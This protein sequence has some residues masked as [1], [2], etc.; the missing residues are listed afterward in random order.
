M[1]GRPARVSP[2]SDVG[3]ATSAVPLADAP[4]GRVRPGLPADAPE[5]GLARA[6][7][8]R[9]ADLRVHLWSR[10]RQQTHLV[11][12]ARPGGNGRE[13]WP[14]PDRPDWSYAAA[15]PWPTLPAE[16]CEQA[17]AG[18]RDGATG[19]PRRDPWPALPDD[20]ELWAPAVTARDADRL[21]RLDRE[22]AGD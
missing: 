17:G 11:A 1:V 14:A 6:A 7:T 12:P 9:A 15:G 10:G 5:L 20:G 4:P 21:A 16:A 3:A 18:A 8:A 19:G 13:G 22:Q 2:A